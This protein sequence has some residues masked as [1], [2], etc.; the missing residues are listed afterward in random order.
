MAMTA[1]AALLA[2][3]LVVVVIVLVLALR[4]RANLRR[5]REGLI[6]TKGAEIKRARDDAVERSRRTVSGNVWEQMAPLHT[7]FATRF[8][9][10]DAHFIGKPIDYIVFDGLDV[11]CAKHTSVIRARPSATRRRLTSRSTTVFMNA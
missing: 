11:P 8:N 1:V 2:G 5:E 3:M 4:D 10:R 7:A 9:P 6:A